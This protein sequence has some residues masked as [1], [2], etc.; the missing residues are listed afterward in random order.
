M[1]RTTLDDENPEPTFH[2]E[3]Q[4]LPIERQLSEGEIAMM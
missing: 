3:F 1:V 4:P 2:F